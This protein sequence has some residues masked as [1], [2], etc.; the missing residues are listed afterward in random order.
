M[1]LIQVQKE[2][3]KV[4]MKKVQIYSFLILLFCLLSLFANASA[5]LTTNKNKWNGGDIEMELKLREDRTVIPDSIG[6]EKTITRV[7]EVIDIF[8]YPNPSTT[9]YFSVA[10]S[11]KI[12][13]VKVYNSIGRIVHAQ[14]L[15]DAT[16]ANIDLQGETAGIYLVEVV[17]NDE[18]SVHKLV[19][20]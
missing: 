12:Q 7:E 20:R 9:G 4:D 8:M 13:A 19:K 17:V 14:N 16:S 15:I 6:Y 3:K 18:K 1:Y 10:S 2:I 5:P 11:E